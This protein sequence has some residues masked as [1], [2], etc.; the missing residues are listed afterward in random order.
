MM[1]ENM[2]KSK[3]KLKTENST[4]Q[5]EELYPGNTK[6]SLFNLIFSELLSEESSLNWGKIGGNPLEDRVDSHL[7][8][9]LGDIGKYSKLSFQRDNKIVYQEKFEWEKK[10]KL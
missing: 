2:E 6:H 9:S 8:D 10:K 4:H 3:T 5:D 7:V 1:I